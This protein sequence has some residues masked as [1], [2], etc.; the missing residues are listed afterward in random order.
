MLQLSRKGPCNIFPLSF[1]SAGL[2]IQAY[3]KKRV[4]G[5]LFLVYLTFRG[6]G[7]AGWRDIIEGRRQ[8]LGF[9]CCIAQS[10]RPVGDVG[11]LLRLVAGCAGLMDSCDRGICIQSLVY[12]LCFAESG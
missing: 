10:C 11:A 5:S 3:Q 12:R 8:L 7:L 9:P 6:V 2:G 4:F 1:E